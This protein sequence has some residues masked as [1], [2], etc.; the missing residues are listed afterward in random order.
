MAEFE[1]GHQRIAHVGYVKLS[2]FLGYLAVEQNMKEHIA[3]FLADFGIVGIDQSLAKLIYLLYGV[4]AQRLIGLLGVPWAFHAQ[5]VE[6]INEPAEGLHLLLTCV[7][8]VILH[9][10]LG[11]D[12]AT[13]TSGSRDYFLYRDYFL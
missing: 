2:F 5:S 9:N 7:R 13:G 3:E 8:S 4:G 12:G 6:Y 10:H 1:F 11:L